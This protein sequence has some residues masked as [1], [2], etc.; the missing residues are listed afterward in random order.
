MQRSRRDEHV[1][2][3]NAGAVLVFDLDGYVS[4]F[5]SVEDAAAWMEPNDVFDGE[6]PAVFLL[7]GRVV[8]PTT[9]DADRV[10]LT[11][12]DE[13]DEASLINWLEA[14]RLRHGVT[15]P[16]DGVVAAA[17]ELL[18]QEWHDRWPRRPRWLSRRLHGDG[19]TQL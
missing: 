7:D 18:L 9:T 10:T 19:P 15:T 5:R 11:V 8:T 6:Y 17:N 12:T 13:R 1:V 4:V 3:D 14:S 16:A 2:S